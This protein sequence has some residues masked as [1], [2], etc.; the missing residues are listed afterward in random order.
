MGAWFRAL[1]SLCDGGWCRVL[2][3]GPSC[4]PVCIFIGREEVL[5]DLICSGCSSVA[6]PP[7]SVSSG[8][9]SVPKLSG[10][11]MDYGL[12]IQCATG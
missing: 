4:F 2:V 6:W 10:W 8:V 3:R 1:R 9:G 7:T 11:S 12:E 5:R